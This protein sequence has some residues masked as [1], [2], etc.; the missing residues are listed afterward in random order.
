MKKIT[1]KEVFESD[2]WMIT[3]IIQG[4]SK[5]NRVDAKRRFPIADKNNFFSEWGKKNYLNKLA[6]ENYGK[7]INEFSCYYF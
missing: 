3:K 7:K 6:Q 1:L 4:Y 5:S 2:N